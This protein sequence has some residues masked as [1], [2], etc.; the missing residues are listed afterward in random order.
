MKK[1]AV[2]AVITLLLGVSFA[3][4]QDEV[5]LKLFETSDYGYSLMLPENFELA[6][7]TKVDA[8]TTWMHQ[9]GNAMLGGFSRG[10]VGG[11]ESANSISINWMWF[12]DVSPNT[13][14][15]ANWKSVQ[16]DM[17]SPHPKYT[18]LKALKIE[19]GRAF[20]YKEV[21][22]EDPTE[23]HRWLIYAVGNKSVYNIILAS[24][25]FKNFES[26]I[27]TYEEVVKS[28]KLIPLKASK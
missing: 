17:N 27:P 2:F 4:A 21:D 7:D 12:P 25:E 24:G 9:K 28:F 11:L 26:M 14:Y 8:G 3:V 15:K 10:L 16:D 20:W 1:I 18:D 13:L 23:I 6:P 19:G 5:K 22:K